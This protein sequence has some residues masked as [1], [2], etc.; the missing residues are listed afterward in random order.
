[1]KKTGKRKHGAVRSDFHVLERRIGAG[2]RKWRERR[3]ISV[4]SLARQVALLGVSC[5]SS[6]LSRMERG[7]VAMPLRTFLALCQTL[8]VNPAQ[9]IDLQLPE[10]PTLVELI[11]EPSLEKLKYLAIQNE[12]LVAD[13]LFRAIQLIEEVAGL[14]ESAA[15]PCCKKSGKGS[16]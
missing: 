2:I 15:R 5:D 8:N 1:M 11:P 6:Y 12:Q 3:G 16:C 9:V 13:A 4:S 7:A 14:Y 10:A